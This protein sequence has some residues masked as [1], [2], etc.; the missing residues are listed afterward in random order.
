[1]KWHLFATTSALALCALGATGALAQETTESVTV[2]GSRIARPGYESPTPLTVQSADILNMA[3]PGGPTDALTKMPVLSASSQPRGS[4]GSGGSGGSFLNL[5]NLGANNTLVLLD[6]Q[7]FVAS[8]SSGSVDISLFPTALIQRVEV[9][10]GGASA[11]YGSDA[12]TGVV[13][14]ILDNELEG[15]KGSVGAGV[16]NLGQDFEDKASL[17]MGTSFGGGRGHIV[18]GG[19]WYHSNGIY[20]L[21]STPLGKRSCQKITLPSGSATKQGFFCDVRSSQAN[22]AGLISGSTLTN[23]KSSSLMK[24]TTFDANGSP[25]PFNYGQYVTGTTMVG[26]D[27][28]KLQFLPGSEPATRAVFYERTSWDFNQ[29]LSVY[30]TLNYGVSNYDYQIGSYD[31]NLGATAL[32]IHADNAYLD[33]S[34]ATY[35]QTNG[36]ASFTLNKYFANLPRTWI[37]HDNSVFRAVL[38]AKGNVFGDWGWD[39]HFENAQTDESVTALNDEYMEHVALASDAVVD[40]NTGRIV[41]RSTLTNPGNGCLPFNMM[42]SSGRSA[43]VDGR[44]FNGATDGQLKYLTGTDWRKTQ[45]IEDDLAFNL[46]GTPFSLW[47][48]DVSFAAG[49][50]W[51]YEA[52]NQSVAPEGNLF[53]P[54]TG[55]NGPFRVGNY[56]AQ[57]GNYEV[58]E[59]YVETVVPLLR[60]NTLGRIDFNGAARIANYSTSGD[61]FTWKAG[62]TWDVTDEVRLRGTRSRDIRAPNLNELFAAVNGGHGSIIDYGITNPDGTHP[63]N[64]QA[65]NFSQGNPNL[66]PE[67]ANTTTAGVV[68]QPEWLPG[69]QTSAD[70]YRIEIN[71]AIGNISSQL[72]V[73]QC[74][75]GATQECQF[76]LRNPDGSLF[77]TITSPQNLVGMQTSGVDFEA[78]YA[79]PLSDIGDMNGT[80]NFHALAN[81][82]GKFTQETAGVSTINYAGEDDHPQW[83]WTLQTLYTNGPFSTFVQM[84]YSGSGLFDKTLDAATLPTIHVPGQVLFDVNFNYDIPVS[85]GVVG[86]Y[87]NITDLFND[88]EPPTAGGGGQGGYG[89]NQ[90]DPLGRFFRTGIRFNF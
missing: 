86:L 75:Q 3:N 4:T 38:G 71:K 1:M 32:T 64:A 11:A 79:L 63:V 90:Y 89:S 69:L 6:G 58:T 34:L 87:L 73:Q 74:A 39:L 14:F 84:R 82:V 35:M 26:G 78:N 76:V 44:G 33:P 52:M 19:E 10:T 22:Y 61:A 16:S 88:I 83:R 46:T 70:W 42:G 7:R 41:C 20:S 15:I 60:D 85:N 24:G 43:P 67:A 23:G 54:I 56:F 81:Y 31:Q 72:I 40:P 65:Q 27:G 80:L 57:S 48:G 9:V 49:G 37:Q 8:T 36:I 13:N 59:G 12:V 53:N 77:G 21:I 47:A 68:Y 25:I 30:A 29:N 50:E 66:K 17:A 2:T 51:R 55:V 18:A 45:I 5:R 28:I 62:L